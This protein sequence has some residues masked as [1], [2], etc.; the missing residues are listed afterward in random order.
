MTKR[1]QKRTTVFG[2]KD[3]IQVVISQV[4]PWFFGICREVSKKYSMWLL[5]I[6]FGI[7]RVPIRKQPRTSLR[8]VS[9]K[10]VLF[11]AFTMDVLHGVWSSMQ[12]PLS[13]DATFQTRLRRSYARRLTCLANDKCAAGAYSQG[14]VRAAQISNVA[15]SGLFRADCIRCMLKWLRAMAVPHV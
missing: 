2:A 14:L 6:G 4:K 15:L 12:P 11:S 13:L 5:G 8:S 9:Q 1:Q 10:P 7:G 3:L